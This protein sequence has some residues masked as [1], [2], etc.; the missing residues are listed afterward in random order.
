M[1]PSKAHAWIQYH[2]IW[3]SWPIDRKK[4]MSMQI[5]SSIGM[6]SKNVVNKVGIFSDSVGMISIPSE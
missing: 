2:F 4:L 6:K 1:S 5:I 3:S